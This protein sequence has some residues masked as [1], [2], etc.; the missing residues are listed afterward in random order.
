MLPLICGGD[1]GRRA[2]TR[3]WLI[4]SGMSFSAKDPKNVGNQL[5]VWKKG[6]VREYTLNLCLRGL[7]PLAADITLVEKVMGTGERSILI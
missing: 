6:K 1:F 4:R 2:G 5:R 3:H 7:L